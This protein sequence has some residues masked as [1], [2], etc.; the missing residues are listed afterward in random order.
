ME[1]YLEDS[2][3]AKLTGKLKIKYRREPERNPE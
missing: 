2:T 3:Q 1:A